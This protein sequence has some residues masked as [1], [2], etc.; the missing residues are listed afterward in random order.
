MKRSEGLLDYYGLSL[1]FLL[2][3]FS[4]GKKEDFYI[5]MAE[6]SENLLLLEL[7]KWTLIEF[8]L[9]KQFVC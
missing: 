2:P 4:H 8:Y 3:N 6:M 1:E 9:L 7:E 5:L